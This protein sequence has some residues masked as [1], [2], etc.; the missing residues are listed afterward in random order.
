MAITLWGSASAQTEKQLKEYATRIGIQHTEVVIAQ[1]KL[2]SARGTSN[3]A[4]K[5]HNLFGF[6][7]H[8]RKQSFSIGTTKSGFAIYERWQDSVNDY[9]IWQMLYAKDLTRE[10]YLKYLQ[11][12]YAKDGNYLQKLLA[13]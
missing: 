2:E 9:L 4:V 5:F 10:Q 3:L 8:S 13:N 6:K 11:E 12:N 1:W 7:K